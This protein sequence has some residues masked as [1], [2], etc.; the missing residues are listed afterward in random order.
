[1]SVSRKV[2]IPVEPFAA[3]IGALHFPKCNAPGVAILAAVLVRSGELCYYVATS[4]ATFERGLL[5]PAW[6]C[7]S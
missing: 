4:M 7:E 2:E 1:M 6:V 3:R 5:W